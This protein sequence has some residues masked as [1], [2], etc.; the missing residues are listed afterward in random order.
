VL[1]RP[2]QFVNCSAVSDLWIL[3]LCVTSVFELFPLT[4][5][6]VQMDM[7]KVAQRDLQLWQGVIQWNQLRQRLSATSCR[8]AT[9]QEA[10]TL[11]NDYQ[12]FL[13][14]SGPYPGVT[15]V[16]E[17]LEALQAVADR[18]DGSNGTIR[19]RINRIFAP[20]V[21]SQAGILKTASDE[22]F[23][24]NGE[25]SIEGSVIRFLYFTTTTGTQTQ[26]KTIGVAKVPRIAAGTGD[27][28]APQ[29]IMTSRL[30]PALQ[31]KT[32]TDFE[33][34]IAFGCEQLLGEDEVDP[35]LRLLIV[36]KLLQ[37]GADGSTFV[38][39]KTQ[40]H[41]TSIAA[42]GV[43]QLTNWAVWDDPRARK[44][45]SLA[46]E[47]LSANGAMLVQDLKQAVGDV[48]AADARSPGP[49]MKW[50]GWLR[51]NA[52][53]KWQVS[54]NQPL[55]TSGPAVLQT[56]GRHDDESPHF[57]TIV[58]VNGEAFGELAVPE[59]THACEGQ[60]VYQK[61]Q[62]DEVLTTNSK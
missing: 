62:E 4:L 6:S 2:Y 3:A 14:N 53:G 40:S 41:L 44:E 61:L 58:T 17:R 55:A 60:P 15:D 54:L 5:L 31:E 32:M 20:R 49:E 47:W 18:A 42:A 50:V 33:G 25:P 23:L 29:T 30:L 10:Q 52:E 37:V 24:L 22:W 12:A 57:E 8:T 7:M 19:E 39:R 46:K 35:I 1:E 16:A 43:S 9:P 51:R 26:S 28:R 59:P 38:R 34:G 27:W 56:L 36:Q 48:T 11:I 13:Q 21:I 45:R